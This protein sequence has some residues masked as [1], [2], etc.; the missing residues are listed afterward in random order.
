[1]GDQTRADFASVDDGDAGELVAMIDFTDSW[2]AGFV[3][4][5]SKLDVMVGSIA[6]VPIPTA[7]TATASA[8]SFGSSRVRRWFGREWSNY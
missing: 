7:T 2:N 3:F 1:M 5:F 8:T 6:V 4:G